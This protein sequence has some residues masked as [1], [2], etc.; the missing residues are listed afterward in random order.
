MDMDTG[1]IQWARRLQG[2][3]VWNIACLSPL[4]LGAIGANFNEACPPYLR[5]PNFDLNFFA[6]DLDIA[7]Q[8]MLVRGVKME[9][10]KKRD[11]LLATGKAAN[12]WALDPD[13]GDIIWDLQQAFGPGSLFGGGIVWGSATDG[14]RIYITSTTSNLNIADLGDPDLGVVAGSCPADAFDP[15]TGFLNGGIYGAVD[16]STGK[17]AWQRCLTAPLIDPGTGELVLDEGEPQMVAGFNEGPV[18]M[19]NGIVYVPG[20]TTGYGFTIGADLQAQVIALDAETGAL[21]KRFPFN[22]PG[23]PSGTL[24]R[25][26]RTSVTNKRIVMGNG[27]KDNFASPLARRVVVYE[28][29]D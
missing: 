15:V 25:F 20:P 21:L 8:P 26:T 10:G 5:G 23:E 2:F 9:N 22:A 24:L 28:L 11:L 29:N 17:I 19:A 27:L 12:I 4:L 18:S 7:E 1:E 3:D 14:E 13:S 6:K 16:L